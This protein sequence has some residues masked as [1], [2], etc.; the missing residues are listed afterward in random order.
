MI[1]AGRAYASVLGTRGPGHSLI[2]DAVSAR[3]CG[4]PGRADIDCGAYEA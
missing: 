2:S 4:S 3:L 1:I